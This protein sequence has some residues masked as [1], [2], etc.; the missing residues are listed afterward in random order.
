MPL[1]PVPATDV[2]DGLATDMGGWKRESGDAPTV[3]LVRGS[4]G[5]EAETAAEVSIADPMMFPDEGRP[6]PALTTDPRLD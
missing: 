2:A 3:R 6:V 1:P 4:P 5:D